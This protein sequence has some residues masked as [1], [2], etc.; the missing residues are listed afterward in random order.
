MCKNQNPNHK[1]DHQPA[2][3]V[4]PELIAEVSAFNKKGKEIKGAD[5]SLLAK[6]LYKYSYSIKTF[7]KYWKGAKLTE[8]MLANLQDALDI[9][10]SEKE[11]INQELVTVEENS[12]AVTQ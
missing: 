1:K 10:Q 7:L 5:Y 4:V 9:I 12:F 11:Q 2:Q 3:K 6:K 8:Q